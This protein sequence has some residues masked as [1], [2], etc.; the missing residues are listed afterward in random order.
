MKNVKY[1]VGDIIEY[2]VFGGTLRTVKV[3]NKDEN[4]KNG[5]PGFDGI[6]LDPNGNPTRDFIDPNGIAH[7]WGYDFQITRVIKR[8]KS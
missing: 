7:V 4:V 8:A 5:E 2:A 6:Q 1:D 3:E